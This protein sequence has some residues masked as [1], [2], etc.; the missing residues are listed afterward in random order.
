MQTLAWAGLLLS[1]P[2]DYRPARIEGGH[3]KGLMLLAD[4]E[5]ARLVLAWATVTRKQFDAAE[6]CKEKLL[7]LFDAKA[8]V[9]QASLVRVGN[10][11]GFTTMF[12]AHSKEEQKIRAVGYCPQTGRVVDCLYHTGTARQDLAFTQGLLE[13]I[14]DQPV[15]Q[16]Y[17]WAVLGSSFHVPGGL[18]YLESTLNLGDQTIRFIGARRESLGPVLVVRQV[19]PAALAMGRQPME[20]WLED[21]AT[22]R[23]ASYSP[24][25]RRVGVR[26]PVVKEPISLSGQEGFAIDGKLRVPLRITHWWMPKQTRFYGFVHKG[27]D[28]MLFIQ[29]SGPADELDGW[30]ATVVGSLKLTGETD[31]S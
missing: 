26:F 15:D 10:N 17:Q 11:R 22:A 18:R 5:R 25:T 30:A 13:G 29:A 20:E 31:R 14:A 8:G 3:N 1:L 24:H 23:G 12:W 28:R 6:F 4:D 16:D 7:S 27:V 9:S 21:W 19:Y 2:E